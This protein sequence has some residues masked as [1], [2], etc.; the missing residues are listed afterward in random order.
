[1]ESKKRFSKSQ[2]ISFILLSLLPAVL[3][4]MTQIKL[5][6][7]NLLFNLTVALTYYIIP[8]VIILLFALVCFLV[9]KRFLKILLSVLIFALF[10][11]SFL[12]AGIFGI[13]E[14]LDVHKNEKVQS[15][16]SANVECMPSLSELSQT[17]SIE[18]YDYHSSML[19]GFVTCDCDTLICQYSEDEYLLQKELLDENYVFQKEPLIAMP[20]EPKCEPVIEVDGYTFRALSVDGYSLIYPKEV[21]F[22]ATNDKKNEILYMYFCDIE[23]DYI[24]SMEE[25]I[26]NDCGFKH[27]R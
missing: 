17:E 22:I 20:D 6:F 27:I 14:E 19:A 18:Y 12:V 24:E 3:I 11:S 1:M 13:F 2:I 16:Y 21:I 15:H 4:V 9:K 23:L 26:L 7:G 25:F 8:A 5:L 10:I